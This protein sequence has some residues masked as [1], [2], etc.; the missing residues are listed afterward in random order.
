[1]GKKNSVILMAA[2]LF[3]QLVVLQKRQL[4][5]AKREREGSLLLG[6]GPSSKTHCYG[7]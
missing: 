4:N 1:M 7:D 5:K 6:G 3:L 2:H